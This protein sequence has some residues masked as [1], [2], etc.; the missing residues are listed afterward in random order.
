MNLT[1]YIARRYFKSKKSHHVIN[2]ISAVSVVGVT[3]GTMALIVVLSVFNGFE[4]LVVSLFN[5]FNP[6]IQITLQ[7]GKTFPAT[8]V[9]Q[10][11][12][13]EIPGVLC[14][15]EVL[16]ENALMKYKDKQT[17][18]TLKGVGPEY[19]RMTGVDTMMAEGRFLLQRGD[20]DFTVLGYGIAY[21]LN[22]NLNDYINPITIFIPNRTGKIGG[23]LDQSFNQEI[24]FPAGFFSIQQ[25]FDSKYA[26]MPIR[27]VRKLLDYQSEITAIEIKLAGDADQRQIQ[28]RIE[29]AI[30]EKFQ[31]RNR[32]QQQELLYNI[33]KSE[34]YAIFLI[35]TFILLLATF[36]VVGSLSMLIL[37]KKKDIAVLQ[38]MGATNRMIKRI[39]LTEGLMISF[40][41]AASGM[42]LGG[43]LC[44]IQQSW[45]LIR[46]GGPGSTFVV[47]SYPVRMQPLDF[48]LVFFTV[49]LI[50]YLAAW[51]PVY[52]IR[53]IST[54]LA[55]LD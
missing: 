3:I 44:W 39:F 28:R 54:S 1:F 40:I 14:L 21:Y 37:D 18:V 45:G 49:M 46:M 17:I 25:E 32:F 12:L 36:N 27:F 16:E 24:I 50:G 7:K 2:I 51:Y 20:Q 52:N 8:E 23:G 53:K 19:Q 13:K 55:K 42:I 34:K 29:K 47:N 48:L 11:L 33:M 15:T 4:Q 35:L 10:E 6:D 43:I 26:L 31:V 5:S 22:A 9:P 38:S 41:G 30:G